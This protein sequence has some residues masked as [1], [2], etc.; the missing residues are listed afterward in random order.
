MAGA[1]ALYL[2]ANSIEP[3][4]DGTEVNAIETAIIKAALPEGTA[5]NPCSYNN[6][7]GSHEPLLLVIGA[8]FGAPDVSCD[9]AAGGDPPD[10]VTDI[11]ITTVSAP[12]TV[13]QGDFVDIS[14][15][16]ENVGNQDVTADI[17][18]TLVS[19]NATDNIVNDSETITGGLAAGESTML[20][21]F[22]WNTAGATIGDHTLTA[23]HSSADNNGMNDSKSTMV[24]VN[25]PTEGGV[26]VDAINPFTMKAGTTID[27]IISGSGFV[28]GAEVTF[29]NGSGPAPTASDVVFVDGEVTLTAIITAKSGGPRRER[30]WDVRVTNPDASFD[31]LVGKFTVTP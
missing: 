18:V 15:T 30:R 5:T 31:V 28:D 27:V 13:V 29:E 2:H 16:V 1:V 23:S 26:T 7:R 8:A 25:E 20:T 14:V 24:T 19:D 17:I 12:I 22:S 11:A 9:V 4:T 10:P 3:A 21:T 6:K